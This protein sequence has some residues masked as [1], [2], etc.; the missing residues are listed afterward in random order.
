MIQNGMF[1]ARINQVK[2]MSSQ[3]KSMIFRFFNFGSVLIVREEKI[4]QA[5]VIG[6]QYRA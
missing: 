6:S 5:G 4:A 1:K 2:L 3:L